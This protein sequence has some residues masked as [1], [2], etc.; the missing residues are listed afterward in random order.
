MIIKYFESRGNYGDR[1]WKEYP[2]YEKLRKEKINLLATMQQEDISTDEKVS[3]ICKFLVI[4]EY[5]KLEE[6][7]SFLWLRKKNVRRNET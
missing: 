4:D 1:L 7:K 6:K 3:L 5:V 2:Q